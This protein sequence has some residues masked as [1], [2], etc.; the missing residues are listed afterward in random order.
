MNHANLQVWPYLIT[1]PGK[2][3]DRNGN[4]TSNESNN[5]V[6]LFWLYEVAAD[7]SRIKF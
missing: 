1:N 6:F 2:T 7:N 5:I 3:E 4:E